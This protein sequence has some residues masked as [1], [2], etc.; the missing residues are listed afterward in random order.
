MLLY[1]DIITGD[2][3]FSDAFPV[4][5]PIFCVRP[6]GYLV[7]IYGRELRELIDDAVYKVKCAMITVK[8]GADVDIGNVVSQNAHRDRPPILN[9]C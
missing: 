2:E 4:Y 8:P 7:L 1:T 6:C 5:V 9:R 3:M